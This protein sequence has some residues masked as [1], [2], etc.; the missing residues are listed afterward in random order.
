MM[1][2]H[3]DHGGGSAT[4]RAWSQLFGKVFL[5]DACSAASR[6]RLAGELMIARDFDVLSTGLDV[7]RVT[8]SDG[9]SAGPS[10]LKVQAGWRNG[11]QLQLRCSRPGCAPYAAPTVQNGPSTCLTALCRLCGRR[12]VIGVEEGLV[13]EAARWLMTSSWFYLSCCPR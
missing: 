13:D 10:K 2:P 6:P 1:N 11:I 3:P 4:L 5:N 8:P 7:R 12:T 9:P